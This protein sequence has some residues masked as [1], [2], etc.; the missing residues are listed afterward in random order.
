MEEIT[1]ICLHNFLTGQTHRRRADTQVCPYS[2]KDTK[3][4]KDTN[5]TTAILSF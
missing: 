4:T 3:D 1:F 2:E 5:D